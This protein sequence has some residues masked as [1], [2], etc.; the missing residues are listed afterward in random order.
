MAAVIVAAYN[1][2]TRRSSVTLALPTANLV[3]SAAM[4][5]IFGYAAYLGGS[6]VYKFGMAVQRNAKPDLKVFKTS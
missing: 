3:A 4:L 1:W 5:P 2:W 6:L